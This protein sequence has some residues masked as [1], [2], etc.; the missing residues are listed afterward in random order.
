MDMAE[1]WWEVRSGLDSIESVEDLGR[2]GNASESVD[3]DPSRWD[4]EEHEDEYLSSLTWSD[5]AELRWYFAFGKES[6]P[7]LRAA[8]TI[9]GGIMFSGVFL[10][11]S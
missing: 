8:V 6:A 5:A 1:A 2:L 3:L 10:E 9:H 7:S 11:R 4:I